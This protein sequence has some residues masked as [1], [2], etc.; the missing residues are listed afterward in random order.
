MSA[1]PDVRGGPVRQRL[2][3]AAAA[4]IAER[5]WGAVSTRAV[6]ERAGV[7]PGVVHYHFGSVQA[8]LTEA[9]VTTIRDLVMGMTAAL[10]EVRDPG[11][12]VRRL[13]DALDQYTGQD[14]MLLLANEAYLAATR[15]EEL[16]RE[17]GA[18]LT[19]FRDWLAQ[20]FAAAGI[21]APEQTAAVV[22]ATID[23]LLL[24]RTLNPELSGT[25]VA[26]VLHR[27]IAT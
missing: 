22:A 18:V 19:E 12:L 17:L 1:R 27:L 25:A 26:R 6:A 24:H 5:G 8:L 9:A 20:R 2:T 11:V 15:N 13:L 4:L 3:T 10:D 16:R 14:P 23:G 21:A 7:A